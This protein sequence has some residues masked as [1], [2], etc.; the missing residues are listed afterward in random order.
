MKV[1]IDAK[2]EACPMPLVKAK[3]AFDEGATFVEISVDNKVAVANLEKLANS[4]GAKFLCDQKNENEF[5]CKI[6][7]V[8][9]HSQSCEELDKLDNKENIVVVI[10]KLVI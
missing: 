4:K 6:E 8:D 7:L 10:A 1:V 9:C 3:K 2:G 5:I